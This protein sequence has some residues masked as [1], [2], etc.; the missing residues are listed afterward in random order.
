MIT[1]QRPEF[2]DEEI[3]LVQEVLDS[4]WVTR[5]KKVEELERLVS[6]YT[7]IPYVLAT[8]SATTALHLSLVALGIKQGDEVIVPAFTWVATPNVVE[9]CGATPVFC[10]IREDYQIDVTQIERLITKKTK[11][12]IPVH[13]FGVS[14]DMQPIM[15]LAKKYRLKVIEDAACALGT[16]YKGKHVGAFGE[17]GCISL[18]PAKTITTGEGGLILTRSKKLYDLMFKLHDHGT[19]KYDC[20]AYNYRLSDI[21]GA[22]GVAQMHNLKEILRERVKRAEIYNQKLPKIAPPTPEYSNNTYQSYI[23]YVKNRD[24]V[25]KLLEERG[26]IARRGTLNVA[27]LPYYKKKYGIK[28]KDFPVSYEADKN[29]LTLPLYVSMTDEEQNKVIGALNEIL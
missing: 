16:F 22:V 10:D 26:I 18:H 9:M 6:Q 14:A 5:G 1:K 28:K 3:I 20:V 19:P 23:A 21:Q 29:T 4:G 8:T 7:G 24:K 17:V 27:M 11:A 2:G 25:S 13:L 15:R 12:I